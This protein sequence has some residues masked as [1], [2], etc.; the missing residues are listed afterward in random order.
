M[1][2]AGLSPRAPAVGRFCKDVLPYTLGHLRKRRLPLIFIKKV[3]KLLKVEDICIKLGTIKVQTGFV[4]TSPNQIVNFR[5]SGSQIAF[6]RDVSL[7]TAVL[8]RPF[9]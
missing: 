8:P 2:L 1:E 7:G 3:I 9:R 4:Q 6:S 5:E